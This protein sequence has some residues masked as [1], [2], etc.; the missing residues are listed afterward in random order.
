MEVSPLISSENIRDIEVKALADAATNFISD[1]KWCRSVV[2]AHLAFAEPGIIGIFLIR[3]VPARSGVDDT[4][5]VVIGDVPPANLVCDDA[6]TWR[7][8]L[9]SYIF[10]MDKWVGAVRSG[11]SLAEVIPVKAA[12]TSEQAEMLASRLRFLREEILGTDKE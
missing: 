9:Q 11:A 3:I 10:E 4:L 12:P 1:Q 7:E 8:A 5:W 6:P 2:S